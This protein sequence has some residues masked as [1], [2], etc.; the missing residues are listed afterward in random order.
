MVGYPSPRASR[1]YR[2][3]LPCEARIQDHPFP[4]PVSGWTCN[5]GMGGACLDLGF[6][7]T[8][9]FPPDSPLR[10][11]LYPAEGP[12]GLEGRV[13][14]VGPPCPPRGTQHGIAFLGVTAEQQESLHS[15][16]PRDRRSW[17]QVGP[18]TPPGGW[19]GAFKVLF[20]GDLRPGVRI[21]DAKARL[22]R[23]LQV[24]AAALEDLLSGGG[25]VWVVR[26][27]DRAMADRYAAAFE[28]A[29]ALCRIEADSPA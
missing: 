5:L 10:L 4:L 22:A 12:L 19:T 1:R 16:I 13:A 18:G 6:E 23:L 11:T 20:A 3:I 29:G 7:W 25:K 15:L 26:Q 8:D 17:A 14:W 2:I 24:D 28:A 27:L 9:G 21:E